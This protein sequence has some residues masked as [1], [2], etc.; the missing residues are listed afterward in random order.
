M[1]SKVFLAQAE[2]ISLFLLRSTTICSKISNKE[3]PA[4]K[5]VILLMGAFDN[6]ADLIGGLDH[7]WY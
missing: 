6:Y 4:G 3:K 7:G 1:R 2:R 5:Y